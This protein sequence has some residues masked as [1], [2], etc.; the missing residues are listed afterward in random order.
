MAERAHPPFLNYQ[1]E[2]SGAERGAGRLT[3]GG[4]GG[5]FRAALPAGPGRV[6]SGC[7][8]HGTAQHGGA[9]EPGACGAA[10]PRLLPPALPALPKPA[11]GAE[12]PPSSWET[13]GPWETTSRS[14]PEGATV[15]STCPASKGTR[16]SCGAIPFG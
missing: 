10:R 2:I 6:G 12:E 15:L 1:P 9:A 14:V 16:V 13:T 5:S 4:E 8:R 3:A 11:S 7:G